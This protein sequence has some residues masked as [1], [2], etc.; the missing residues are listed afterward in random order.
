[1]LEPV[2]ASFRTDRSIEW[3][4]VHDLPDFVYF[5]HS[6]HVTKGVGCATCH[7]RVDQMPLM[8]QEASLQMEWCLDCHRAPGAV[9]PAARGGLQHGL[10]S[11]PRDQLELGRAARE[12]VRHPKPRTELLDVPPMS[13][14]RRIDARPRRDPRAGWTARSGRDYWRSL[15]ELAGRAEFQ[16]VPAPRVPAQAVRVATTPSSR[17]EFL[18]LMGA[19]LALAGLTGCTRQPDREDRPLRAGARGRS[20]PARPL[21]F[22]TAMPLG[23]Y[24]TGVLVESH[25]GRPTKVEGNPEHPGEPRR[26]RR[27]RAGVDPRALRPRPLADGDAPSARSAPWSDVPRRARARRS[28]RSA[29]SGGAG[30]RILTETVTSPTLAGADRARCST[31][32]P[33]AR[34]HQYEPVGARQRARRARGWRSAS[35]STSHYRFDAGRRDPRARRR[36][37]R[38]RAR[39]SVRYARDFAAPPRRATA[40]RR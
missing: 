13:D 30:L 14:A 40:R 21:F 17:R 8:W 12:G 28:R 10:A 5:N 33:Q 23:G 26:D 20:C 34:W 7:G 2:R 38:Q 35:R 39:R 11:R 25:V 9:R 37:P 3:T 32:F 19:S 22:A 24:A 6:I 1:M 16:R 18:Q 15:E 27:L 31:S 36:L 29:P 4:R